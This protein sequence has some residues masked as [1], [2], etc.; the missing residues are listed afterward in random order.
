MIGFRKLLSGK[1]AATRTAARLLYADLASAALSTPLYEQGAATDTFDGRAAM[2]TAHATVVL[3]RL[4]RT[5]SPLA[6]RIA[7][8]LNTLVLD[9]FD[10]A[11]REMGVGDSSI[12]RKV[13]KLAEVHY[14]LGKALIEALD[15]PQSD[16]FERVSACIERNAVSENGKETL[17]SAYLLHNAARFDG[18]SDEEVVAGKLSWNLPGHD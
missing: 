16:R 2:I 9:G 8:R 3:R 1:G 17:L 14:G 11:Y 13:R 18:V 6:R 10:A 5:N 7:E 4:R 12:A 15:A